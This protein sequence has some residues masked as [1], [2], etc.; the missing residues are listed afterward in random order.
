MIRIAVVGGGPKSLFALLALHDS[1]PSTADSHIAVDVYDPS[2]PGSGSVWRTDQ[3]EVLRLNVAA[4]IVDASSSISS[5]D[6]AGWVT[7]TAPE[8]PGEKYPPRALVGRYLREQYQLLTQCA[9]M[10]LI[11]KPF[12]VTAIEREESHWQVSGTFGTGQ[13]EE[14]LLAMGHGLAHDP[15]WE[16][17]PG[18]LNQ[19]PLI[20]DYSS[21][22]MS[23]IPPE[24]DVWIRGAALTAYD[25][26]LLLTEGRGGSW[27]QSEND[28]GMVEGLRYVACGREPRRITLTSR[29]GFLMDPKSET[30]PAE[31]SASMEP[32]K[33][34]I[35]EWAGEVR[36]TMPDDTL[37]DGGVSL[38]GLWT[39]LLHC[40]Q[41]C[42][43]IMGSPVTPLSLWRTALT[44]R[45]VQAGP[46]GAS[47]AMPLD[48]L[49]HLRNSV[50]VN[51]RKAPLTTGWLWARVW[52]GLYA[53]LVQAMDRLPRS[54]QAWREFCRVAHNLERFTFG[55][56]EFTTHKLLAL[57]DAGILHQSTGDDWPTEGVLIDAVTPGPGALRVAGGRPNSEVIAG[58]LDAGE[59]LIRP[60]ERGLFTEPDGTCLANDG[61]RN[62]SLAALGRLT[63]D[64]TLGHDTLNRGLHG[65]YRLWARRVA[66]LITEPAEP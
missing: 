39:V 18:A 58:L 8:S 63:E 9:N 57:F 2:P 27:R 5:E 24:S 12:A 6:F 34:L 64:P 62:E 51:H 54:S 23:D 20:G 52:S 10:T 25:V 65:D 16:P 53:E 1:L 15:L 7:R 32:Y 33:R 49:G 59:V 46:D 40:A 61:S 29:S 48:A 19:H 17:L 28:G 47:V 30:V 42:A 60:G 35:R 38:A 56:P 13:Y 3:P 21:L 43:R 14:V 22:S 45:S 44:G 31:I 37:P 26:A 50:A 55:P 11:H 36:A 41:E 66:A 4:G